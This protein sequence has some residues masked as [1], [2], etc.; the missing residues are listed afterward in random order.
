MNYLHRKSI[1]FFSEI[2]IIS[3]T[4]L[5][6][7][8]IPV[9][10]EYKNNNQETHNK[11]TYQNS[12]TENLWVVGV[13]IAT[14]LWTRHTQITS[15]PATIYKDVIS[16]EDILSN[17]NTS[18][19]DFVTKNMLL[20]KEYRNV[21]A[22][23]I[24]KLLNQSYD[25][26]WTLKVYLDT[27]KNR[28]TLANRQMASLNQQ[29]Q[30]F[31]ATLDQTQTQI[32][33]IKTKIENDF[34]SVNTDATLDNID[35]YLELKHKYDLTRTYLIFT[36]KF[37]E[38]YNFLNNYNQKIAQTIINNSDAIIKDAYVVVPESWNTQL[39]QDLNLL[40]EE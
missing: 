4:F 37:I 16:I 23:N 5:L 10:A 35:T 29:K 11:N 1:R 14:N 28:Y 34:Q 30:I 22:T 12:E 17:K 7:F 6:A 21:S 39:L 24:Q 13:A 36:N 31:E 38:Q 3:L 8:Q 9:W 32:N 26:Q 18:S 2:T 33:E 40:I 20:I 25:K 27:L 19:D 15:L